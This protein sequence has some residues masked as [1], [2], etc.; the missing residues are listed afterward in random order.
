MAGIATISGLDGPIRLRAFGTTAVAAVT[1]P[2]A[3]VGAR[4]VL[5]Q[6]LAAIDRACSRFR[7]DSELTAVNESHGRAV[8]V[9]ALFLEALDVALRGARVTHGLVDPTVGRAMRVLG[10]DRDFE[11][12]ERNGSPLR[13]HV[14]RAPGWQCVEIDRRLRTVRVP[15]GV[16]LDFGATAKAL[17]ADRAARN[18]VDETGSGVIVSIGGDCAIAGAPPEGGW[19]VAIA[20]RHD[21]PRPAQVVSFDGGGLATS[22][23]SARRWA[24]GGR[25]FH[26][27]V[28]PRSGAPAREMWRTV[29]V[30]A[31]S[32]VDANI[33]STAAVILGPDAL[34]WIGARALPARLVDTAG[35]VTTLGA[36]PAPREHRWW[37]NSHPAGPI[38]SP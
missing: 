24:R 2:E 17:A 33:A 22:G 35:R 30:A 31:A 1:N 37:L 36:W 29:T 3:V 8:A 23:T 14:H 5:V 34:G 16:Q 9:S 7:A 18:V 21:D 15:R 32:C 4:R 38:E 27:I 26:H 28:D 10:Y 12:L 19:P 6:E 11:T 20:D 25:V 13:V